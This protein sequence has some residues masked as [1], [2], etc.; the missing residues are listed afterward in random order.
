M[1][2]RN[3][4]KIFQRYI[5]R[6]FWGPFFGSLAVFTAMLLLGHVFGNLYV[7]T[8]GEVKV[9]TFVRYI[10]C[11]LPYFMVKIMPIATL[12]AVLMSL[13]KMV[14]AGEWKA[15]MA[16]GWRPFDMLK[17]L[18]ICSVFAGILQFSLQETIA[19]SLYLKSEHIVRRDIRNRED[20]ARLVLNDVSF[21][22]GEGKFITCRQFDGRVNTMALPT[23]VEYSDFS[24]KNGKPGGLIK[25]VLQ[26][27][28]ASWDAEGR[29]WIFKNAVETVYGSSR[30]PKVKK[31]AEMAAKV[32]VGPENLILENLVPDGINISGIKGRIKSL[33]LIG[34]PSVAESTL[35]WCKLSAP[36]A[37][38][39]MALIGAAMALLFTGN[40]RFQ[41]Y[42]WAIGTGFAFWA[43]LVFSQEIGHAEIL[44]PFLSGISPII[45]F[46]LVSAWLLKKAK[47]F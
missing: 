43:S 21:S 40:R 29:Q 27:P 37:N 38:I 24:G 14:S 10:L 9:L 4:M 39:I 26:S 1:S 42:G 6:G 13:S 2:G 7:F 17:P 8:K 11:Q 28:E 33:S 19:P 45:L 47:V 36:F 3:F 46:G 30:F 32:S 18:I 23:L 5:A 22:A 31:Y 25:Y 15:G 44:S 16:G 20:W 35:M 12:L 34:A 41:S